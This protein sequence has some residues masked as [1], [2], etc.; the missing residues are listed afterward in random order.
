[1][2]RYLVPMSSLLVVMF[3]LL[4]CAPPA[5]AT[6]PATAPTAPASTMPVAQPSATPVAVADTPTPSPTS[7][8]IISLT[9]AASTAPLA[10]L[11]QTYDDPAGFWSIRYPAGWTIRQSGS[12][13]QFR[14]TESSPAFLGVS[15]HVKARDV[16]AFTQSIVDLLRSRAA[17]WQTVDDGP[18]PAAWAPGR[19]IHYRRTVDGAEQAGTLVC[20]VRYRIGY[21]LLSEGPVATADSTTASFVAVMD[22]FQPAD[23][24]DVVPYDQWS[25]LLTELDYLSFHSPADSTPA[26]DIQRIAAAY[27]EAYADN[28]AYLGVRL[29]RLVDVYL[30]PTRDMRYHMTARDAGFAMIPEYE[31]HSLWA[32]DEQQTPGH[33]VVHV[34]TGNGWGEAGEALLGEGIAVWLDHSGRDHHQE[35]ADLLVS[36]QL[37]PVRDLLGDGWFQ[38][39]GA[40]TYP[41]AGSLVGFML[42]SFGVSKFKRIYLASDFEAE[43]Q[44]AV[45][46]TLPELEA[47]WHDYLH[48]H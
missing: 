16:D 17:A 43:L 33:E 48:Q 30:Y 2:S 23:F 1:M 35:A 45:G 10:V 27:D 20:F 26:R 31:V 29:D 14:P 42:E 9:P 38:R 22:S 32:D 24:A 40:I 11:S 15:L 41:E 13:T 21:V 44:T 3:I 37:Y 8:A 28:A 19:Q 36:D 34:L 5:P 6:A 4:A 39:D 46:W 12:E 7:L 25:V 18:T 47:A